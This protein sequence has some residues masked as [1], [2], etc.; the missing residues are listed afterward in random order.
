MTIRRKSKAAI[1]N[2]LRGYNPTRQDPP[3][4]AFIT[5]CTPTTV[6]LPEP[7]RSALVHGD[8]PSACSTALWTSNASTRPSAF[9]SQ[10]DGTSATAFLGRIVQDGSLSIKLWF[11]PLRLFVLSHV[12]AALPFASPFTKD[13]A[14]NAYRA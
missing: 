6:Q 3:K 5:R 1:K 12:H 7:S 11:T 14:A 9:K 4:A 10:A 13:E 2:R 8:I